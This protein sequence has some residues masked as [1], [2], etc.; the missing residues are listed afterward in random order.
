MKG[1][2]P[3]SLPITQFCSLSAVLG[4]KHGAGRSA[5]MSSCFHA[6]CAD[7]ADW[8]M[9]YDRLTPE[10]QATIDKWKR[11][12]PFEAGGITFRYE[13]AIK[14]SP[15]GLD[16][17]CA[18]VE[19]DDPYAISAG[20]P[21]MY[22]IVTIEEQRVAYVPD[23][24]RS[25]WTSEVDSL[26]LHFYGLAVAAKHDCDAYVT[27]I[28]ALEEGT[29]EWGQLIDVFMDG[30][31][32]WDRVKAAALNTGGEAS[33]GAHCSKCWNRGNCPE[34]LMPPEVGQSTLAPL[35]EGA[36]LDQASALKLLLACKRVEDTRKKA[37]KAL[38]LYADNVGGIVSEDGKKVWSV[39]KVSGR[40]GLDKK[41]LEEDYPGL[42]AKY[43]SRGPKTD[44]YDWRNI[45]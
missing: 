16:E 1:N 23:L 13:D 21:D 2:R 43:Q 44:R 15:V 18:P 4:A 41:A 9:L 38:K 28:W 37:L 33:F 34:W 32:I 7:T 39:G 6:K 25:E 12:E 31:G 42:L 14:E 26:Q 24:K 8:K 29:W 40:L 10:E 19:P 17:N 27:G 45:K 20:T 5:A 11:P 35:T 3:S 30:G 22:W 36:E